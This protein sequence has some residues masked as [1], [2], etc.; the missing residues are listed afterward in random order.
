LQAQTAL[1]LTVQQGRQPRRTSRSARPDRR[2]LAAHQATPNGGYRVSHD[3][4][5]VTV[6]NKAP[7]PGPTS[8]V[9][10]RGSH[11]N[12]SLPAPVPSGSMTTSSA[13]SQSDQ[14]HHARLRLV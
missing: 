10:G 2:R 12:S 3:L 8:Q 7:V 1:H 11:G 9:P 14:H 6:G 5:A 13:T 4:R